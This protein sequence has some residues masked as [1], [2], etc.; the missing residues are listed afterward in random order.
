MVGRILKYSALF[1]LLGLCN[2]LEAQHL[3][4]NVTLN[5]RKVYVGEPVE[6]SVT[7]Y[8]STWFTEGV[9]PGNVKVNGAYTLYFRSVSESTQIKG[10]TY[11]GVKMIFNVFPYESTDI[12]F[13][14]L[15]IKVESPKEGDYKGS[16]QTIKTPA[17]KIKVIPVP[18][19]YKAQ[20]LVASR[21]EVKDKISK[22]SNIKVGDVIE[23]RITRYVNGTVAS[24]IPPISWDTISGVGNY[25]EMPIVDDIKTK[26][27]VKAS[28]TDAIRYLFEKEGNITLPAIIIQWWNPVQKKLFK[29]TLKE[30]VINVQAN[31]DPGLLMS[32]R[33]S[34]EM[35]SARANTDAENEP[36]FFQQLTRKQKAIL[37][38]LVI[39]LIWLFTRIPNI[40]RFF[41]RKIA[42]YRKKREAYLVS[43]KYYFHQ[44]LRTAKTF[45][46]AQTLNAAYRWID[47]LNLTTPTLEYF[48]K[49]FAD[50]SLLQEAILLE[51][52]T[53]NKENKVSINVRNWMLARKKFH[54]LKDKG[55]YN[56][57][58]DWINPENS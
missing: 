23:R 58:Y 48:A 6:V 7:V 49:N 37:A 11:A 45:D 55:R 35:M 43:E 2:S 56:K 20:W 53:V 29:R 1:V 25:P 38:F 10:K 18:K 5:K 47:T 24:L 31:P 4:G 21:V 40:Y 41:K 12:T 51:S 28:R 42:D 32:V 3:W 14:S 19:G 30:V 39:L 52:K 26:T 36:G 22:R 15:S 54:N 27:S 44:F 13:P 34:L 16:P 50:E 17:K 8:T 9:D 46:N 57:S 33:D